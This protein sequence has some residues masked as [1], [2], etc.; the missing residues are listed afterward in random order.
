MPVGVSDAQKLIGKECL[1]LLQR[2]G[3]GHP[4]VILAEFV[5]TNIP[6][7]IDNL[8]VGQYVAVGSWSSQQGYSQEM[9][10]LSQINKRLYNGR[11]GHAYSISGD[12]SSPRIHF[13]FPHGFEERN[14]TLDN[15]VTIAEEDTISTHMPPIIVQ[16]NEQLLEKIENIIRERNLTPV[17]LSGLP[18]N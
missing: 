9:P 12:L 7:G 5:S 3:V 13:I 6:N 11:M 16:Q 1:A 2:R 8:A 4:K 15:L 14:Y 10:T 18:K 17:R